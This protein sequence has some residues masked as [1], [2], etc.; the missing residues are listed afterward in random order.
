MLD[1]EA[2]QWG[3]FIH[4]SI[5]AG[6]AVPF[7][8]LIV[9]IVMWLM[10]KDEH[11]LVDQHGKNVVNWLISLF[12]YGVISFILVFVGIG[13]ILLWLLGILNIIFAIVGGLKASNGEVWAYPFTIRVLR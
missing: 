13:I 8:G 2:K 10:K 11:Y 1:S 12:V 9:P 3:M 4:F 5:L 7:A 6:Y